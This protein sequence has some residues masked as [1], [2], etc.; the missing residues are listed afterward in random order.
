MIHIIKHPMQCADFPDYDGQNWDRESV[1]AR[2]AQKNNKISLII[3]STVG[4]SFV[5]EKHQRMEYNLQTDS[6]TKVYL[7]GNITFII[8]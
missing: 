6:K 3:K 8:T 1:E 4:A 5:I 7:N 2:T